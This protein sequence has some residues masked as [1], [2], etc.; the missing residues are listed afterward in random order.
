MKNSAKNSGPQRD[1]LGRLRGGNPGNRGGRKGRS[2]RPRTEFR[3]WAKAIRDGKAR[4]VIE[5]ILAAPDHRDRL[6][7][8]EYVTKN[9]SDETVTVERAKAMVDKLVD[10]MVRHVDDP[11]TAKRIIADVRHLSRQ[12]GESPDT[13]HS[14]SL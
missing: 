7:A 8:V 3:Q 12:W 14:R 11:L 1:E 9:A 6:R 2:G 10:I 13:A 5:E 4:A